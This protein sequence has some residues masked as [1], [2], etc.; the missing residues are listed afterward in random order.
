MLYE[1]ITAG[2]ASVNYLM[3]LG[4]LCGGWLMGESALKARSRLASGGGDRAF[5]EAKV[6]TA[7]FYFEHYLLV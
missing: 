2:A 3:L 7:K 1:V 4:Y 6:V 5:L